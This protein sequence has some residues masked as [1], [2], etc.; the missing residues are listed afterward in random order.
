M[1][2]FFRA[3]RRASE[4]QVA[5]WTVILRL[6]LISFRR[7]L[8]ILWVLPALVPFWCCFLGTMVFTASRHTDRKVSIISLGLHLWKASPNCLYR[9]YHWGTS[10]R[11]L[12]ERNWSHRMIAPRFPQSH[13][14]GNRRVLRGCHHTPCDTLRCVV[15]HGSDVR[16]EAMYVVGIVRKNEIQY[17]AS[18]MGWLVDDL[19]HEMFVC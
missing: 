16:G 7:C 13:L 15:R 5:A 4:W 6:V 12:H 14:G 9:W 1:S 18:S 2:L 8:G 10:S 19:C 17:V 3:A 11:F